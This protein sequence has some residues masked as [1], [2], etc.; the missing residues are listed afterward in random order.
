MLDQ[1]KEEVAEWWIQRW[2]QNSFLAGRFST[3]H[4]LVEAFKARVFKVAHNPTLTHLE[5]LE[6]KEDLSC[7]RLATFPWPQ[8]APAIIIVA[9]FLSC[10]SAVVD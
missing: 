2:K 7:G 1:G 10:L 3:C 8:S 6:W 9:S 5:A 4:S